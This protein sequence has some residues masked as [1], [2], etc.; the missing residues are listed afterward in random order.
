MNQI[1][2]QATE[3]Q[4]RDP[5][6][7]PLCNMRSETGH[8]NQTRHQATEAQRRDPLATPLCNLRSETGHMNQ[9]RHQA[10][11]AQRFVPPGYTTLRT[12]QQHRRQFE[13]SSIRQED[14]AFCFLHS[15]LYK[16]S[17]NNCSR[18]N[19]PFFTKYNTRP[20]PCHCLGCTWNNYRVGRILVISLPSIPYKQRIFMVMANPT[21]LWFWNSAHLKQAR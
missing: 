4:R 12:L 6:A 5:L 10:T 3:A 1:R 20:Q 18:A 9:T 16:H 19:R 15:V 14:V 13:Q 17:D 2:H 11:E 8:M 21:Q 7:T